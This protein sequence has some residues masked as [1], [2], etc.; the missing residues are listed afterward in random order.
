MADY[1]KAIALNPQDPGAYNNR[2]NIYV[3]LQ[4]YQE[5]LDD[6][7][8]AIALNPQFALAYGNRGVCYRELQRYEEAVG[9][10]TTAININPERA[11]LYQLRGDAYELWGD[12]AEGDEQDELFDRAIADFEEA[13]RLEGLQ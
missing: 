10:F 7:A 9:D 4:Q 3:A 11:R 1:A 6:Y 12:Q 5:A 8:K 13:D 2:G